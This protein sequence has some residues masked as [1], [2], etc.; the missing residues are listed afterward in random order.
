MKQIS[1]D[2]LCPS[3]SGPLHPR[4]LE[5]RGCGIKI[6]GQFEGSEFDTLSP[7]EFHF[8]RI[9]ISCEGRI[10]DM[11]SA[12]GVS[13]PTVKARLNSLKERLGLSSDAVGSSDD[14]AE[15]EAVPDPEAGDP[16]VA[17]PARED[18]QEEDLNISSLLESM[19]KGEIGFDEAMTKL[20]DGS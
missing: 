7:D 19:E 6:E 20:K 14:Q 4:V 2:I 9:F 11:E 16:E 3:C 12:L 1:T 15:P 18:Q 10:R 13:Y 8:L 5:C 17:T